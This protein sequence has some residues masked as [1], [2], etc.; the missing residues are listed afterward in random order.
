[1]KKSTENQIDGKMHELKGKAKEVAGV[2]ANKPDLEAEGKV[3]KLGGK[4]QSKIGQAEKV[5][6]K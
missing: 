1:M 3:E 2:I 5:L 4:V 6:D